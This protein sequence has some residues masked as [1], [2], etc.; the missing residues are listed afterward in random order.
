MNG[1]AERLRQEL[2]GT[3]LAELSAAALAFADEREG[4]AAIPQLG[5]DALRGL[6]RVVAS[7]AEAAYFLSH[8]SRFLK[9]LEGLGS[10]SLGGRSELFDED[11]A[12]ILCLDL[13]GAL[14]ALRL[15]RREEMIYAACADL[16]GVAS[17]EEVSEFLSLLAES[18]LAIALDLARRETCSESDDAFAVIGMGKL[19]GRELS[20]HSDLDLIFLFQGGPDHISVASRLGQRLISYLTTMTGAGVAYPVDT[21][22]RPSGRQGMLVTSFDAF[23]RYQMKDAQ[24]WEKLAQLRG[25]A[26]AGAPEA[27][28]VLARVHAHILECHSDPWSELARL[29]ER[30]RVERAGETGG[31]IALKTGAGGLM[32]VDFLAGGGLLER[33]TDDFPEAPSVPAM[34]RACVAGTRVEALLSDYQLLRIVEARV[35]W[36][37]G[38]G[39][40]SLSP[41]DPTTL[42]AELVEPGLAGQELIGRIGDARGR[43]RALYD[44][45]ITQGSLAALED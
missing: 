41:D 39:V 35:R 24:T 33:G 16:A 2:A 7:R 12:T 32:D 8:R 42:I 25:R 17:F 28:A 3:P 19:A 38:R 45:V 23:E 1:L 30:V 22:L 15:R 44:A 18:T 10:A 14:D 4:D 40:E 37:A 31:G 21:R 36:V 5:Q 11:A 26:V 43:I 6:A 34:L 20:Y 13:E 29:R 9:R 27:A